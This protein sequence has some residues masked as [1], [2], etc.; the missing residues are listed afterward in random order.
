MEKRD[1]DIIKL[2]GVLALGITLAASLSK[3]LSNIDSGKDDFKDV[4]SKELYFETN[5]T[6]G[7]EYNSNSNR[8]IDY[9]DFEFAIRKSK[10]VVF[11]NLL[12][13]V[14]DEKLFHN[15][16]EKEY[17]SL[18][19]GYGEE[20]KYTFKY[21]AKKFKVFVDKKD[22]RKIVKLMKSPITDDFKK[23][24]KD[25]DIILKNPDVDRVQKSTIESTYPLVKNYLKVFLSFEKELIKMLERSGINIKNYINVIKKSN[26]LLKG[27]I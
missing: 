14:S 24:L 11:E 21:S 15:K 2:F 20:L 17:K 23:Y 16:S 1:K 9:D 4:D 5:Y 18:V 10:Q 6:L 7:K 3:D 26:K 25:I 27:N 22:L 12:N 19:D 13:F 8:K